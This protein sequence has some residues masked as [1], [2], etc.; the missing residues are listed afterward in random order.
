MRTLLHSSLTRMGCALLALAMLGM[1]HMQAQTSYA[2]SGKKKG[3][4]GLFAQ[5]EQQNQPTEKQTLYNVL[6]DLNKQKGVYFLFS[7]PSLGSKPVNPVANSNAEIERILEQ[8]LKNT[9]MKYKKVSENAFVILLSKENPKK[10]TNPDQVNFD[11]P[12]N[13]NIPAGKTAAN[14]VADQITGRITNSDGVPVIGVSVTV[15]GTRKGTSTN[16]NGEFSIQANKGEI[17][18]LSSIGYITQELVVGEDAKLNITLIL[19]DNQM[20]EIVVTALG[21]RKEAKRL[22]YAVTKVDG[23]G[24]AKARE[25]NVAN[26]L[27]GRIAGVNISGVNGGPGSSTNIVIRGNNS[28]K[29]QSPLIVINGVPMDNSTRGSSGMWGGADLG[30]GI[31][32]INPDDIEEISVLKGSTASA[33]Y[34]SRASQGVI[35]ITTKS[36]KNKKGIGVEFNSNLV[37]DDIID[38]TE[39]QYE[40]GQGLLGVKPTS[41]SN[42]YI[43]GANSWGARIDNTTAVQ[44]DGV[45]RPYTAQKDNIKNFYRSGHSI[46]NTI[47]FSG[48]ND[49]GNFRLSASNLLNESVVPNSGMKRNTFNLNLNSKLTKRLSLSAV[50]NYIIEKSKNR[51]FLSDSPGNSNFGIAFLPTTLSEEVLRPGYKPDGAEIN[52]SDNIYL[53]NPWFA[54]HS[55]VSDLG[56]NRVI[57]MGMLR[58]QLLD[59]LTLQGRIGQDY[60]SD[61]T[62]AVTPT[63]TAYL[64]KGNMTENSIKTSELNADFLLSAE[65]KLSNDIGLDVSVGGNLMR[66]RSEIQNSTGDQF[67]VPFLYALQNA[68]NRNT[69]YDL[70]R[71]EV[72]SLYYTAELSYKGMIYLNTTGR[73][74]WF[75]TLPIN[76]NHLFYPSVSASFIFSEVVKPGWLNFGKVR[77]AWANTSGKAAPYAT[78]LYYSIDGSVNGYPIGVNTNTNVPNSQLTP[79]RLK[80]TEA[81]IEARILNSKIGFGFTWFK[82]E[83]IKEI[84]DVP[85][86]PTSG[87]TGATINFG[88]L[89]NKGIELEL[90]ASP[91][92]TKTFSWTT[93]FNFTKLTNKVIKLSEGQTTQ[94]I[95][96]SRTRNAFIHHVVG[97][98]A[99][100]IMAFDYK[101][102]A[103]GAIIFDAN[104]RPLQGKLI[105][106]G[107]GFHDKFGG[108]LN[109]L[110]WKNLN[111]GVLIDFKSGGKIFSA[112][113]YYATIFG[114]HQLTLEGRE[115]GIIG[116]GVSEGGGKNNVRE[117]A[118]DYYGALSNNVS[119][120][121]V[122]D[123]SFVKLRQIV[124]GYNL[125]ARLYSK[126]R[127]QGIN[128]SLVGR[129]LAVLKKHTPNIDPESNYSNT[130]AQ[131]LELAG[132]PPFRSFGVNINVK[133]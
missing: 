86:S 33:L 53:T 94:Q 39:Y 109:E 101:R 16:T 106:M 123:A 114:L 12:Q 37:I 57:A 50:V 24:L 44:F 87:Y 25:L 65:R 110:T 100:Q 49:N 111:F 95:A 81:G 9:G 84:I 15:K 115:T 43:S 13:E 35:L 42:A 41:Q 20:S 1:H 34:G 56:R 51:P 47:A 112:T 48:G 83:T 79:F 118:W 31:S 76:D 119:S 40:Y 63:G 19:S 127:I 122:Y 133:F 92:R 77:L 129:N 73:E 116:E 90:T 29:T 67:N 68:N 30:D 131:G 10:V 17:L 126:L 55:F 107:S 80:E 93:S 125:P 88:E 58:Y 124:I 69:R 82:R 103:A 71:E 21:I 104:G 89:E 59:W 4:L 91:V 98:P 27:E 32:N 121:F 61:R 102:D 5:N 26:G 45:S 128:I 18:V 78:K 113:N 99:S 22:G 108:W 130:I 64:P 117:D 11:E 2:S 23:E 3:V 62:T 38:H 7:D 6:K 54:S 60:F 36:G 70:F 97:Q 132:V 46:T 52:F 28:L 74:D 96:E 66:Y 72:Q 105:P 14:G 85:A 75:S 8:V 120:T